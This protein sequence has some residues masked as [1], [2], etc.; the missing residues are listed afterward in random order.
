MRSDEREFF[1]SCLAGLEQPLA[2]ELHSLGV[3]RTRP[4][5]AGVALFC[6]VKTALKACLWSR[7]ASRVTMIVG[8]VDAPDAKSLYEGCRQIAWEEL[9][10]PGATV[11][12]KAR[13]T[14]ASLRS[15]AFIALKVKDALVDSVREASGRRPSIDIEDPDCVVEVSLRKE[16]AAISFDFA[17]E[18][19]YR[20][21]YLPKEETG[22]LSQAVAAAAGL[23]ALSGWRERC[24][25][26]WTLLD[27]QCADGVLACECAMIA[28]DAAPGLTRA[29][30]GFS[31]L[32]CVSE[33]DWDDLIVEAD[34]RLDAGLSRVSRPWRILGTVNSQRR[35]AQIRKL[36][37]RAGMSDAVELTLADEEGSKAA[38]IA[39]RSAKRGIVVASCLPSPEAFST[40]ANAKASYSAFARAAAQ[41]SDKG[42]VALC[43]GDEATDAA[44]SNEPGLCV[45]LGRGRFAQTV[46]VYEGASVRTRIVSIPDGSGG[47]DH[48]V[49]V[50]DE[51][52]DQFASRLRKNLRERRKWA[53]RE[54]I[55]CYRLYDADLP[56][57]SVA[58]D[59]YEGECEEG[60][61]RFLHI[62]E[63]AAPSSVD[64]VRAQR[65]FEDVLAIAPIVCDVL[66]AHTFSKVRKRDKGGSQYRSQERR[67]FPVRV[68]EAGLSFEVD[69]NGYLDTG[70]FLDHRDTRTMVGRM[71]AGKRFLNL[72]A[73]TGSATVHAAAGGARSTTTVDLSQTYLEWALRNM[74]DNGFDGPEHSFERADAVTWVTEARR[75]G[76]RF[77]LVFV[78]PPT[79]SNSK[80]MGKRTWDVQR[81][82]AELLIGIS[83]LLSEDGIA[84]F[85]CN[86]R[87]FKPDVE[88]LS[89]YGVSVEDIS[90]QT[91]PHDFD[92]N[93]KIHHCYLAR[94]A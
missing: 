32:T 55:T 88:K 53:T 48:Q 83:R 64:R 86:L 61:G 70:L 91:I 21:A 90:Q 89:R 41:V 3:R 17:G 52:A 59:V 76:R 62:A 80:S 29:K 58:V 38:A 63:Y 30:W 77:D 57:F 14:N 81:D 65:R 46:R 54:G 75:S 1:A 33:D 69:L 8:R 42:L 40:Q 7:L 85:S 56:D 28:A 19:L 73:Y 82:H 26:G 47:A 94:R 34:D 71:A 20:R 74:C 9:I 12:V 87:S 50:L 68:Q 92:R 45:E 43:G 35:L 39:K 78:D 10:K 51:H 24:G 93:P 13:G 60:V 4:L 79:F 49:A 16:R 23:A 6:D 37:A 31:G 25:R 36:L 27:P 44:F 72:F 22:P 2:E 11:S 66:P 84:V 67:P 15:T 5:S 18:S